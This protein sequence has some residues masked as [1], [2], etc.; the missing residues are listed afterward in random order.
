MLASA[1]I[2][3]ILSEKNDLPTLEYE[4]SFKN[5]SKISKVREK[6]LSEGILRRDGNDFVAAKVRDLGSENSKSCKIRLKGDLSWHWSG[7]KWSLRTEVKKNETILGRSKFS[8]QSPSTRNF[9]YEWLYLETLRKHGVIAPSY[10]F[11]N[12]IV[13][14]KKMGIYAIEEHF[15]KHLIEGQ[16]RREGVILA[17][18]EYAQWNGHWNIDWLN[19]YRTSQINIRDEKKE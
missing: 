17:F 3:S 9:T 10:E 13:N 15:S 18:D 4:I 8:I 14:G 11:C 19:S 1:N 6:A 2:L 12:V 5:F 7:K 16:L